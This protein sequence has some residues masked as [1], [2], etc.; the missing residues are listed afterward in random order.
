MWET[1]IAITSGANALLNL[2]KNISGVVQAGDSPDRCLKEISA[3]LDGL[4][5]QVERLS[6]HILYVPELEGVKDLTQQSQQ[7]INDL[8]EIREYLNPIQQALGQDIVSS[9][10]VLTPNR[11]LQAMKKNPWDVL[12]NIRPVR[13]AATP[14]NPALIPILFPDGEASFIGW[15]TRGALHSLFDCEFNELWLPGFEGAKNISQQ[16]KN[17]EQEVQKSQS[18]VTSPGRLFNV[19][20]EDNIIILAYLFKIETWT[21]DTEISNLLDIPIHRVKYFL[22]K[23]QESNLVDNSGL[24]WRISNKGVF[25]L[26]KI[27]AQVT[28]LQNELLGDDQRILVYL[29]KRGIWTEVDEISDF[30]EIPDQRVSDLLNRLQEAKLVQFGSINKDWKISKTGTN[31]LIQEGLV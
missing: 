26:G 12:D 6:D 23:L 21:H 31:Y 24:N 2:Y 19:Q 3:R 1:L 27:T 28:T 11:L 14:T 25:Y 4:Q 17:I 20:L 5:I 7:H 9:S 13:Y 8:R 29:L 15:T 22:D 16:S 18:I 30:L 10:M